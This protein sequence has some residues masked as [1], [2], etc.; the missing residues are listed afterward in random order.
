MILLMVHE[1]SRHFFFSFGG[2]LVGKSELESSV[3]LLVPKSL[4]VGVRCFKGIFLLY[5]ALQQ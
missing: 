5:W 4:D 2:A 3:L 1:K